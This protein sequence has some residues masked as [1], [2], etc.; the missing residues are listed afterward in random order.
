M[1][2]DTLKEL[3]DEFY[4]Q[5][6]ALDT[7]CTAI[8][9]FLTEANQITEEQFA[10]YLEQAGKASSV[11]WLANRLRVEQLLSS[12]MK[13]AEEPAE[14]VVQTTSNGNATNESEQ[15]AAPE[16]SPAGAAENEAAKNADR[17]EKEKAKTGEEQSREAA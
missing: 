14:Q 8:R 16:A 13:K 12:A 15:A 17:K 11:R 9:R 6:E 5:L 1:D 4:P 2:S 3:L 7:E 10:P